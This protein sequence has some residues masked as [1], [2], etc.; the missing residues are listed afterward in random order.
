MGYYNNILETIGKTPLVK[1][2][3][4]NTYGNNL[5][6]KL[7]Y[8]NPGSSV[9]DRIAY[10]MIN[11]ALKRNDINS[12]TTIIEPT[13]G[14]TGIGLALVCSVM[15][16][17]LIIVMPDS[18]SEERKKI[19][20]SFGA[21]L[22]LTPADQGMKGSIEKAIN[23][24]TEIKNSFMPYQFKNKDNP[25]AHRRTT[26]LEVY[27]DLEGKIDFFVAGVG[28]G[29]TITGVG[30]VLKQKIPEVK[31]V[32]VEPKTSAVLSG[33]KP[34]KHAIQGIGAGFIPKILNRNIIDE[35]ITVSDENAVKTSRIFARR[36]GLFTG[37][38]SGAA[39]NAALEICKKNEGQLKNI[40]VIIAS[41]GER[42]LTT[43]L[44]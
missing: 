43:S 36:E 35:V 12:E 39:L 28:T 26:A 24:A 5:F 17:K 4:V 18:M 21:S 30:E 38:S 27:A 3:N 9:K 29:G 16:L 15:Q 6:A 7:E 40:V 34:G 14:N 19:I 31:I 42:Y 2:N 41:N 23:L 32:A 8:F 25:D 11:Q 13:S 22:V 44:Y 20:K 37:F 10:N 33:E 1:I